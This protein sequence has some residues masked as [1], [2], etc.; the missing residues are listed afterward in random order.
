LACSVPAL[1][2]FGG[3]VFPT[4]PLPT[5]NQ[6][7]LWLLGACHVY[8][9]QMYSRLPVTINTKN[10]FRRKQFMGR[11]SQVYMAVPLRN[12]RNSEKILATLQNAM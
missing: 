9:W 1:Q 5:E 10:Q 7:K 3:V 4:F 2:Y 8:S 6:H 12:A 11:K